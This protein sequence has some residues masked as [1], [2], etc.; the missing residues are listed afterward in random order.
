MC[1]TSVNLAVADRTHSHTH[2]PSIVNPPLRVNQKTIKIAAVQW[3][4]N[5]V[6]GVEDKGDFNA[7]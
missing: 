1:K 7:V 5:V 2:K 6:T 4:Y 3:N